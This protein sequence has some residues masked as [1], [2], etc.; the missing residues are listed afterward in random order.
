MPVEL[1][2]LGVLKDEYT[3]KP[4][5]VQRPAIVTRIPPGRF[6]PG[7]ATPDREGR[8]VSGA[9]AAAVIHYGP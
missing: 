3:P 2:R 6:N 5:T 1:E 4:D 9:P 7:S 8:T